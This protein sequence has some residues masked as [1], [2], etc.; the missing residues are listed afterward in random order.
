M[1]LKS[2]DNSW[3]KRSTNYTVIPITRGFTDQQITNTFQWLV[4][5]MFDVISTSNHYWRP[6]DGFVVLHITHELWKY[7]S[8]NVETRVKTDLIIFE[9]CLFYSAVFSVCSFGFSSSNE[10]L[11]CSVSAVF[12]L[13]TEGGGWL[14]LV[15]V[16]SLSCRACCSSSGSGESSGETSLSGS[17]SSGSWIKIIKKVTIFLSSPQLL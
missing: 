3:I 8:W 6:P 12:S 15:V 7:Y 14:S 2:V 4:N 1:E 10:S 17:A 16:G 5:L 13:V 9:I 11:G